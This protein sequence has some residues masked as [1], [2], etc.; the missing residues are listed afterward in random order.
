MIPTFARYADRVDAGEQQASYQPRP[1]AGGSVAQSLVEYI[2]RKT[3][4]I[5]VRGPVSGS[6]HRFDNKWHRYQ[7]VQD[8]D[9]GRF[10]SLRDFRVHTDHY[11]DPLEQR[12]DAMVQRRLQELGLSD[13]SPAE[14]LPDEGKQNRGGRPP[15][16]LDTLRYMWHLRHHALPPWSVAD[17]AREFLPENGYATPERTVSTRLSR[18]KQQH[19]ELILED[20]C[21]VCR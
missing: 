15:V 4:A 13:T 6:E 1:I 20:N 10:H 9:L 3:S 14:N 21:P 18:F 2:G 12:L 11:I 7:W 8:E 19:P 16:P 5:L 17:L